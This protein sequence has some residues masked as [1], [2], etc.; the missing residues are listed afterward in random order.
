MDYDVVI[1]GGGPNG[2]TVGAYL[3]KA[4][5]RCLIIERR[6]EMGG[7][8]ITE[9]WGGFRFNLHATYG[10][11]GERTPAFD[12]LFLPQYGCTFF[13]PDIQLHFAPEGRPSLT[14]YSDPRRTAKAVAKVSPS[15]AEAFTRL[16]DDVKELNE[17]LI[18]PMHY[19][20]PEPPERFAARLT[21]SDVGEKLLHIQALSPLEIL[22]DYGI[23]DDT[24]RACLIYPG[25][26]WGPS[27]TA[28]GV[29]HMFAFFLYR[30]TNAALVGGGSHRLS[31]S[32]LRAFHENRGDVLENTEVTRIVISDGE[33][34]GVVTDAGQE[35]SAK[36]V[37]STLNPQ[38]T[39]L[40]LIGEEHLETDL[41]RKVKG[42][43]W[44]EWS[45]FMVHLGI[46]GV[47]EYPSSD[48]EGTRGALL[49][50]VG[51]QGLDDIL[52][53]WKAAGEGRLPRP[54]GGWTTTSEIDPTQAPPGF[55]VARMETQVPFEVAGKEWDGLT[56]TFA[57]D[58]ID[59]WLGSLTN[60][61]EIEIR[62][63]YFYPPT[64][65]RQKLPEMEKGSIRHGAYIPEQMGYFRPH[66]SSS[67]TRT[68]I[69]SLYVAGASVH[70]GGMVTLGPGYIA[71]G[72]IAEDL[73]IHAWWH[74][75]AFLVKARKE[76]FLP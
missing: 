65:I 30:M 57:Q 31:S 20:P 42:W 49:Q 36:A 17:R 63:R 37:V 41:V 72:T 50:L 53:H 3:S 21:G 1:I 56:E 35:I 9:D 47:P 18:I 28:R 44:D 39:F 59:T 76:G 38:Q 24:V 4:G 29:G 43:Q 6:D 19:A 75:P 16:Y 33:A 34:K 52:E 2:E 48:E 14:V 73:G 40:Q 58:C 27:P 25:C 26:V 32:L 45:M 13:R 15:D 70:P 5:A 69:K 54:E 61:R 66:E 7:G 71:A 46:R 74:P 64:Y 10:L 60:A 11:L 23:E 68:P 67:T 22:D 51:Y 12:D 8:L 62:K 55:H